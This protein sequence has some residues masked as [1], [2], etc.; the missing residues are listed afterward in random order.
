MF[1]IFL[2]D[3]MILPATASPSSAASANA[4]GVI[5]AIANNSSKPASRNFSA[6]AGPTPGRS[7]IV[8]STSS[9]TGIASSATSSAASSATLSVLFDL[10]LL[11]MFPSPLVQCPVNPTYMSRSS[12]V[13]PKLNVY[14]TWLDLSVLHSSL[15]VHYQFM[16]KLEA[17]GL[18]LTHLLH[19][20]SIDLTA[21]QPLH[22]FHLELR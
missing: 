12:R 17:L 3:I 16:V 11:A 13:L 18:D 20:M 19:T 22:R 1:A 9:V 14:S 7:S 4:E 15:S 21:H 8:A 6:V 2:A 10:L 5:T